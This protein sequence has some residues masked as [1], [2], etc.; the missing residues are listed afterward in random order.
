M[1]DSSIQSKG[2][3]DLGLTKIQTYFGGLIND[4]DISHMW[5]CIQNSTATPNSTAIRCDD[6]KSINYRVNHSL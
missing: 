4:N 6:Y 2:G 5:L 3:R 1:T